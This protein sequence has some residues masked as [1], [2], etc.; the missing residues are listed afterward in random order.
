VL[1]VVVRWDGDLKS[2][3][4]AD[5]ESVFY[6][7]WYFSFFTISTIL[8]FAVS[9]SDPGYVPT[10]EES[11]L[12]D[13][14]E[15]VTSSRANTSIE[16]MEVQSSTVESNL[17]CRKDCDTSEIEEG[18]ANK[19]LEL[20][21]N[22]AQ[23]IDSLNEIEIVEE[24]PK[25][26]IPQEEASTRVCKV[27]K[28]EQPLRT[29][30]CY[31]CGKCV[32]TFDHHCFW[33]GNCVGEYNHRLFWWYLFFEFITVCWTCSLSASTFRATSGMNVGLVYLRI[34]SS[35]WLQWASDWF[36]YNFPSFLAML[37]C[38]GFTILLGALLFFHS[39]LVVTGQTTWEASSVGNVTY[40]KGLPVGIYPFSE[41]WIRNMRRFCLRSSRDPPTKW[42]Q[43]E[44]PWQEGQ[45]FWWLENEYW[46]CF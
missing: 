2:S 13:D 18:I 41:G 8:Y 19:D 44:P 23:Y 28:S 12:L 36:Y 9:R 26:A 1:Y 3:L 30:H 16:M 35:D 37:V 45:Q 17:V 4:R 21:Q 7:I 27:C 20:D 29:K 46:S 42:P 22:K 43:P 33:I 10:V 5:V 11:C 34:P 39:Y 40:L 15:F 32:Y 25:Q 14:M 38:I 31:D 24:A 6:C